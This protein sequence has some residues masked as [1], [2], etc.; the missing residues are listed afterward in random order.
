MQLVTNISDDGSFVGAN[1]SSFAAPGATVTYHL[2]AQ[3]EG[4]YVMYSTDTPGGE[5]DGGQQSAG[6]FGAINVEPPGARWYR[7]QVTKNDLD[8]APKRTRLTVI[9]SSTMK[10]FFQWEIRW[11]VCRFSTCSPARMKSSSQI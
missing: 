6:L 1:A 11:R 5:G 3:H 4:G 9:P 2:F 7:S 8:L 10:P